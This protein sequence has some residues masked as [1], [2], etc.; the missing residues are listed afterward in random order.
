MNKTTRRTVIL[1]CI[2]TL[3]ALAVPPA[4]EAQ[5]APKIPRIGILAN[6]SPSV[7]Q[8]LVEAFRQGMRELGYNDVVIEVRWAEGRSERFPDLA[9]ELVRLKVDIIVSAGTAGPLAAKRA[10]ST[11]PI[12]MIGAGDPVASGLVASLARPGGNVTGTSMTAPELGGKRLQLLKEAVPRLTRV[13]VLWNPFNPDSVFLFKGTETAARTLGI[14]VQSL[15]V[16]RPEDFDIAFAA[17]TSGR[18]DALMTVDDP[19]MIAHAPRIVDFAAKTHRPAI[20]GASEY[21]DAGGLMAYGPRSIVAFRRTLMYVDKIL[22]GAKP[23]DLPVIEPRQFDLVI[24]LLTSKALGLTI[25]QSVLL[26]ADR[27]VQ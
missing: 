18:A 4:A 11:I 3:G 14:Q 6:A 27:V 12:V 23:A 8:P 19:L 21:V 1:G 26:Q 7:G 25:P 9:A 10:T 13:A 20:Y 2:F 15:E 17:M 5:P 22:K 24:N 16:R